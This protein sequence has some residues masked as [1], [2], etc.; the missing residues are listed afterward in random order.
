LS[1]LAKQ[2]RI[3][4]QCT[5]SLDINNSI[6]PDSFL[7]LKLYDSYFCKIGEF[8]LIFSAFIL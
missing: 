7:L 5:P 3:M 6:C 1:P 8:C 4:T 2:N